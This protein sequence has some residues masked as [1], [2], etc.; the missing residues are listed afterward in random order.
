LRKFKAKSVAQHEYVYPTLF[1]PTF[2]FNAPAGNSLIK[3]STQSGIIA[4]IMQ[5]KS[6]NNQTTNEN[7]IAD[8]LKQV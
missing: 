7:K 3:F 2:Y 4:G 5:K 6:F 8:R 1:L